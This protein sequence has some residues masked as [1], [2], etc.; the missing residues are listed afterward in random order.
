MRYGCHRRGTERLERA[1]PA[2]LLS[3]DMSSSVN[4]CRD[5]PCG[6]IRR[7]PGAGT[8]RTAFGTAPARDSLRTEV[9]RGVAVHLPNFD[10]S[11][12]H[13]MRTSCRD[14][15]VADPGRS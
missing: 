10:D 3:V 2:D 7:R 13:P 9:A 14:A 11:D 8:E 4:S 5:E 1:T 12:N 15:R 6:A